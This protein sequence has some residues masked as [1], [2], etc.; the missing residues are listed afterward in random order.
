M[1]QVIAGLALFGATKV[2]EAKLNGKID[3]EDWDETS[4]LDKV[5]RTSSGVAST[6]EDEIEKSKESFSQSLRTK[7][8]NEINMALR[9]LSETDWR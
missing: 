9:N 6:I 8:D 3:T 2:L 1:L 5:R 4:T 7:E